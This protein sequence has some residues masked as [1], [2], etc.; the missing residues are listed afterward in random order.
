MEKQGC[1]G[2]CSAPS[3]GFPAHYICLPFI[4]PPLPPTHL[5]ICTQD[6]QRQ[7]IETHKSER[8]RYRHPA[9][10]GDG[11]AAPN[12]SKTN[13]SQSNSSTLDAVKIPACVILV[14]VSLLDLLSQLPFPFPRLL[15]ILQL[16]PMLIHR[17]S[18][19]LKEKEKKVSLLI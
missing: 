10:M 13:V 17:E 4:P 2:A 11:K 9:P 5:H 6:E 8:S 18:H 16:E 1:R 3:F 15:C 14:H 7:T 19:G 12:G